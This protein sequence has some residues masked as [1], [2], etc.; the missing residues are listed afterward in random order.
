M[1]EFVGYASIELGAPGLTPLPEVI[2][3]EP[4]PL[5]GHAHQV[6]LGPDDSDPCAPSTIGLL[7]PIADDLP[8]I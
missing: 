2:I 3:E 8:P 5:V 7:P 6:R 1:V 4:E